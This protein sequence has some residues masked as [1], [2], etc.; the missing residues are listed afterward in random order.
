MKKNTN[1]QAQNEIN[2]HTGHNDNGTTQGIHF[3]ESEQT[4]KSIGSYYHYF[5]YNLNI[6]V[7]NINL[8]YS[9]HSISMEVNI[10]AS[11]VHRPKNTPSITISKL[12]L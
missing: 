3:P 5:L 12:A 8:A 9:L 6:N 2:G 10:E 4:S 11:P 7:L 1:S